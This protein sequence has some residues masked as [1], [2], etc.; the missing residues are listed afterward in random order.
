MTTGRKERSIV[1]C[2]AV[3]LMLASGLVAQSAPAPAEAATASQFNAGYII[4]DAVFYNS[5]TMTVEQIQTFLD[6]NVPSCASG[7]TCLK[8]FRSDTFSRAADG[9]CAAYGGA[10]NES[11]A[12]I[13]R[14]VSLACQINPQVLL[15]ML[16][17]EQGLITATSPTAGKY[18]IA[19]GYGC[20][21]TAPCDAQFYG[22][23]NQ[24]YKA[25]WQLQRYAKNPGDYNYRSGRNNAI[26]YHPNAACGSSTVYIQNQ[27]TASLYNY[28]PYQPNSAA[29]ANLSGTGDSCSSYGNRNFWRNFSNWFGS[30]IDAH[31][32]FGDFESMKFVLGGV[33][34]TGW[35]LDPD[36]SD[37]LQMHVY[38]D[39]AYNSTISATGYR[40]DV[41]SL[42]PDYGTQRGF[43]EI[44][45]LSS[46]THTICLWALNQGPG[47]VSQIGGCRTLKYEATPIGDIETAVGTVGGIYIR[48]WVVDPDVLSP[49]TFHA[50][51]DGNFAAER[52]ANATRADVG[53]MFP[54]QGNSHGF[55]TT[56]PVSSGSH[57][58]CLWAVN[59]G[60][61]EVAQIGTCRTVVADASPFGAVEGVASAPGGI[62]LTGWLIDPDSTAATGFHAYV[63]GAYVAA[64]TANVARA[65]IAAKFPGTGTSRGFAVTVPT[66]PGKHEVCLWALNVGPG[67]I[68]RIGECFPAQ[69]GGSPFGVLNT[70]TAAPGG[71]T[72]SGWAIDPDTAAATT[73][74]VQVA[75]TVTSA[76]ASNTVTLPA[77]YAIYGAN[78]GFSATVPVSAEG[79]QKVCVIAKNT[80]AGSDTQLGCQTVTVEHSPFG[81][82]ESLTAAPGVVSLKGWLI[83][84]DVTA[85]AKFH[86]Y[87]NGKFVQEATADAV[88]TDI[89]ALYPGY[90]D[91][92]G[93]DVS[94]PVAGGTSTVC[95]WALNV[96]AGSITQVGGA[97]KSVT[98]GGTPFGAFESVVGGMGSLSVQGWVIDPDIVS[99]AQVHV[100]ID[101]SMRGALTAG[102]DRPDVATSY[103]LYG[104][105]HGFQG[106]Y[107]VA[108]G[109]HTVCLWAPNVG[110][111]NVAQIGAC[112]TVTVLDGSPF[113]GFESLTAAAGVVSLKG[114]LIDPDVTT[115]AKFH[116]Y[117]NGKFVQEATADAVRTDIGA[118]YPGY[119]DAHGFD[120]SVPVAGG[121]STVCLWALNVG[122]GSITQ[123]G[124]CRTATAG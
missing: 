102:G 66:A 49:V 43:S 42:S 34:I 46:A 1:A 97:C 37:P 123:I 52:T 59:R 95:L 119:G 28:T 118:L 25:A 54:G 116:V 113:G 112:R 40:S 93:F 105:G 56:I 24:V 71:V 64:Y 10:A 5:G 55:D 60:G 115:A 57:T 38:V 72:V 79:S 39:G 82:F 111:G 109:V 83:D 20:P 103:P 41:A 122:A 26:L 36:T 99:A 32:P 8:S 51:V 30:P 61:G 17:K 76:T 58:I 18:Q 6:S 53:E 23:Y 104:A 107:P 14:K 15:V 27:A 70:V 67:S 94:V 114:W 44:L 50:Y 86:V 7:Y 89:G 63:D 74:E 21:D 3:T 13:M 2:I 19:M 48:G 92:H 121:T 100:Y 96:G 88:R 77:E 75:G 73:I 35:G 78:H 33:S 87:V 120:V 47:S 69:S 81:G 31:V 98:F 16:Q 45:P 108:A 29:L 65:D 4:S 101:G 80:G 11:A 90:G 85:A 110:A 106:S 22:F 91:A 124:S 117:V 12:E 68:T 9:Q 62:S 84:P